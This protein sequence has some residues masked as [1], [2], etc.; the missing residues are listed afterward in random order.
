M[1]DLADAYVQN[2]MDLIKQCDTLRSEMVTIKERNKTRL[3]ENG[4]QQQTL[5]NEY[6]R[7]SKEEIANKRFIW[8]G[9]LS[10]LL[11]RIEVLTVSRDESRM[12]F[13]NREGRACDLDTIQNLQ[14]YLKTVQ[15]HLKSRLKTFPSIDR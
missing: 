12:R 8:E 11:E 1:Q 10:Y 6:N 4:N 2:R 14:E 9:L 5:L 15:F 3:V 13:E 7:K